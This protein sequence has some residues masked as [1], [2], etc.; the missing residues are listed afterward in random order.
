M[1]YASLLIKSSLLVLTCIAVSITI[2]K[3]AF[4]ATNYLQQLPFSN[5]TDPDKHRANGYC[6]EDNDCP[7]GMYC[8]SFGYCTP[9]D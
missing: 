5:E 8:S 1:K 7:P 4:A 2:D 6:S 3:A 9:H